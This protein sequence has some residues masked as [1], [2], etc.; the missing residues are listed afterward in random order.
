MPEYNLIK[1]N[2]LFNKKK[3]WDSNAINFKAYFLIHI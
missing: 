3:N 2:T 1:K